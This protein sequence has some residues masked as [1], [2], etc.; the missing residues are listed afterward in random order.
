MLEHLDLSSSMMG[1]DSVEQIVC[2]GANLRYLNLKGTKVSSTGVSILAGHVPKLEILS[3]AHTSI[4]DMAL[5]HISK[6]PS[7]K[8]V[9]LSNTH[10]KGMVSSSQILIL[11]PIS[12]NIM[13]EDCNIHYSYMCMVLSFPSLLSGTIHQAG[14]E[15]HMVS[16]LVSLQNLDYLESLSLEQTPVRDVDLSPLSSCKGLSHLS[17]QC[18][19]LTDAT[20]HH[21]VSLPKLTNLA[22]CEAVLTN[23]GLHSFR[24]P[25]ALRVLDLRGCWLLTEDAISLFLR[26]HP[27]I[28]VWHEIVHLFPSE[29][30]SSNTI[31]TIFEDFLREQKTTKDERLKY[32]KEELLALQHSPFSLNSPDDTGI[33]N[34]KATI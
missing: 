17:L 25:A 30:F 32:G 28:E 27:Q 22:V 20:L 3:L 6:M 15:G 33:Y 8:V 16:S 12:K 18:A 19:S 4:D 1:D 2:I 10:I 7:L 26:K 34:I 31:T 11:L 9:D 5:S 13:L 21:M 23:S 14:T 29:Q 24:P